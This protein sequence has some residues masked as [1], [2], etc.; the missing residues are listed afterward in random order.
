MRWYSMASGSTLI[1]LFIKTNPVM[2]E[3][4]CPLWAN[5]GLS[6]SGVGQ[7]RKP[8]AVISPP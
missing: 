3:D 1:L 5:L 4:R 2:S 6:F 8:P 7:F